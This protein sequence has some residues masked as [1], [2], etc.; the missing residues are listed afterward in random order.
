MSG[1]EG[2]TPEDFLELNPDSAAVASG[3]LSPRG[4]MYF[5]GGYMHDALARVLA[6]PL[7]WVPYHEYLGV[8]SHLD[9]GEWLSRRGWV[10]CRG[11]D[12]P[13]YPWDC[14]GRLTAEQ[15]NALARMGYLLNDD[16]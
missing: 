2:C 10:R 3:W 7:G 6:K 14:R 13:A 11:L 4:V 1:F 15:R 5:C 12:R 9:A 16:S 8:G